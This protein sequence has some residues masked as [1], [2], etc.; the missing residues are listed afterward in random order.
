VELRRQKRRTVR[1]GGVRAGRLKQGN[2]CGDRCNGREERQEETRK[3][4][5][6]SGGSDGRDG[7]KGL[8]KG[9]EE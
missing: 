1:L 6:Q 2:D 9:E 5:S 7:C 8:G 3:E 4:R